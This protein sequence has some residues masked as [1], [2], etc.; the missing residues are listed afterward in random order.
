[1]VSVYSH[2]LAALFVTPPT[3]SVVP[4][5]VS[6][7]ADRVAPTGSGDEISGGLGQSV[8]LATGAVGSSTGCGI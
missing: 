5:G 1:M 6:D 8:A 4:E 2:V 7:G 3:D